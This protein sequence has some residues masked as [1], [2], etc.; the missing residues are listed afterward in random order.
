M[1]GF[2]FL[3]NMT[4]VNKRV[5]NRILKKKRHLEELP[6]LSPRLDARLR[7]DLMVRY[8][9]NSNAIEGSTLSLKETREIVREFSHR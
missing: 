8:I 7:N 3:L 4:L 5:Y 9:Y 2:I 6:P 1:D